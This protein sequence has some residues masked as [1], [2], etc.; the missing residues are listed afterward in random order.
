MLLKMATCTPAI[1]AATQTPATTTT[2]FDGTY[3]GVSGTP[4]GLMMGGSWYGGSSTRPPQ[5]L[6]IVNGLVRYVQLEG[7]VSQQGVVLMRSP[8]ASRF[9]GQ[10][11]SHGTLRG[12]VTSICSFQLV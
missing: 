2:A 4:E 3:I 11:D 6:T 12:Q 7:S 9:D 8:S 5:L 1:P 10:I